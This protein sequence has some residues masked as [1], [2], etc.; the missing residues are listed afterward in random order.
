MGA[1]NLRVARWRYTHLKRG[2]K[3]H[4][5]REL[6]EALHLLD[7]EKL[8]KALAFVGQPAERR[9]RTNNH[10]ERMN[11]RPRFAEKVHY[12]WRQRKW[13]VRYV[14]LLLDVWWQQ[15][16][17]VSKTTRRR[18]QGERP[19]PHSNSRGKKTAA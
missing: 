14:V 8:T 5:V 19:P 10:V 15:A 16:A 6:V 2:P 4:G 3:Y 9:V 17:V 12:R 11:R 18:C 1:K 7:G 13:V